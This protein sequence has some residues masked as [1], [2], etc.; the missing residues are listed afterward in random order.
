MG[1]N[2]T[3]KSGFDGFELAAYHAPNEDARRGGLRPRPEGQERKHPGDERR[4][5]R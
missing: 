3:L 5:S 4:P 2:V 1:G